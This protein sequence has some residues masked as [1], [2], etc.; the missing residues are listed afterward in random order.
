MQCLLRSGAI[1]LHRSG[2]HVRLRITGSLGTRHTDRQEQR[3]RDL[4]RCQQ[5]FPHGSNRAIAG[6]DD[7]S[8]SASVV[9]KTQMMCDCAAATLQQC[10][11]L[12]QPA[13]ACGFAWHNITDDLVS[14]HTFALFLRLQSECKFAGVDLKRLGELLRYFR[15]PLNLLF[16][17]HI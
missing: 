2:N 15:D 14:I 17:S 6:G 4:L 11:Q 5:S 13:M 16:L 7:S 1:Q 8:N 9:E 3:A 10:K 12:Y